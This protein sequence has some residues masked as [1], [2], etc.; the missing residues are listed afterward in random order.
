MRFDNRKNSG[1]KSG[2]GDGKLNSGES[3]SSSG[4]GPKIS[5]VGGPLEDNNNATTGGEGGEISIEVDNGHFEESSDGGG[6][7]NQVY[8]TG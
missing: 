4:N 8:G 5:D 3:N 2:G 7:D 6:T 1:S